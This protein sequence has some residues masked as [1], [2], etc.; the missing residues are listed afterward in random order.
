MNTTITYTKDERNKFAGYGDVTPNGIVFDWS[1][2]NCD[3]AAFYLIRESHHS[4]EDIE[5]AKRYLR[6]DHDVVGLF[7]ATLQTEVAETNEAFHQ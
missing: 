2:V 3:G 6:S 5:I 4:D 1:L 7:V